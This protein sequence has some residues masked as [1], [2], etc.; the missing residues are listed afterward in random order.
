MALVPQNLATQLYGFFQ[1]MRNVTEID[2]MSMAQ[3]FANIIDG[4][5]KT[6][7]VAPGIPVATAGSPTAQTGATTGPGTLI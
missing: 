7:Q 6:A 1:K 2:D 3:E 4:Y 5:I